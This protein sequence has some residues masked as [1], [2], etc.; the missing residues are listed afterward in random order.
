[1]KTPFILKASVLLISAL[2]INGVYAQH[3]GGPGDPGGP[4]GPG[5]PDDFDPANAP[6]YGELPDDLSKLKFPVDQ[7]VSELWSKETTEETRYL[8]PHSTHHVLDPKHGVNVFDKETTSVYSTGP[9]GYYPAMTKDEWEEAKKRKH[10]PFDEMRG[11]ID[12]RPNV[13]NPTALVRTGA[14]GY[15]F[16]PATVAHVKMTKHLEI[17]GPEV[18]TYD[19]D[20]DRDA[21]PGSYPYKEVIN[22]ETRLMGEGLKYNTRIDLNGVHFMDRNFITRTGLNADGD[23]VVNVADGLIAHGSKD[24][25][26]GGQLYD[27]LQKLKTGNVNMNRI[28][29][30]GAMAAALAGLHPMEYDERHR[31]SVAAAYGNYR[32]GHGLAAGL[33]YRHDHRSML[34][35]GLAVSPGGDKMLNLGASYRLGA[36]KNEYASTFKDFASSEVAHQLTIKLRH[37]DEEVRHHAQELK[38][39]Q[40]ALDAQKKALEKTQRVTQQNAQAIRTTK[41]VVAKNEANTEAKFQAMEKRI[42]ELEALVKRLE[43]KAK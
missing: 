27:E 8:Q 38:A 17:T 31:F 25:I 9:E 19:P 39:H 24:A 43:E 29:R 28:N 7:N 14:S 18:T 12:I 34:S 1:M 3:P 40:S 26:N 36:Q 30:M 10:T 35:A 23:K 42:A 21:W 4:G 13:E 41:R 11:D 37:V 16:M 2:M 6:R 33:Y 22:T 15:T 32:N 5:G 20:V